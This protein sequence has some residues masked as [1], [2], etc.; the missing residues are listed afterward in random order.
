MCVC[1][2]VCVCV[3]TQ[4]AWH[5]RSKA[6]EWAD[7]AAQPAVG[8]QGGQGPAWQDM[9]RARRVTGSVQV[10]CVQPAC[11]QASTCTT[12]VARACAGKLSEEHRSCVSSQQASFR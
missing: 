7:L 6:D 9:L 5:C 10:C 2:C 8:A 12:S 1:V 11:V 3:E 4:T